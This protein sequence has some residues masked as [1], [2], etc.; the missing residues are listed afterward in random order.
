LFEDKTSDEIYSHFINKRIP[1]F[2]KKWNAN[3]RKNINKQ[4]NINGH[5]SDVDVANEFAVYFK[6][7]FHS[8][9]DNAV[10]NDYLCKHDECVKDNSQS[11]YECIESLT[12][13]LIDKCVKKL[14]LGKACGPDDL[15]AEHLLY[16][17]PILIM[18]LK[19]LFKLILCHRFVP[20][21]FAKGVTVPLI[22]DTR[23]SA[24]AE[25]P[26]DASC[27]LKSCQL[28]RNSAETTY[29]TSPDQIDGMKLEI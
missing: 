5:I 2:W 24:I 19:V 21:S 7:V 9:Y 11:S 29:M 18:H 13:K 6:Q 10:Y 8:T 22:K 4:V 20:N 27:Q 1:G 15:C 12:V 14:K 26:R 28:P 23:S 16:A 3:F 25:G 17:H